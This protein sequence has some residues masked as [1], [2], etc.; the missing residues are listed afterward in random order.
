MG[1][2]KND[3]TPFLQE[4]NLIYPPSF[5]PENLVYPPSGLENLEYPFQ[6]G[7]LGLSLF[8]AGKFGPPSFRDRNFSL[9][10]HG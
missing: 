10:L 4:N 7:K 1:K 8:H 6:T 9:L 2:E 5:G 3:L